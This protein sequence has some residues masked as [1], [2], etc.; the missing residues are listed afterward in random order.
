VASGQGQRIHQHRGEAAAL[1]FSGDGRL[2]ASGSADHTLWMYELS[3]GQS[4]K[5]DMSGLGILL[6]SFSPDSQEVLTINSGD[7]AIMRT[8]AWPLKD[9]RHTGLLTPSAEADGVLHL[10]FSPDGQRTVSGYFD[11]TARIWDSRSGESRTLAGHQGP[12]VWVAFSP[13]GQHVL[14]ASQD[15][16]VRLWP[17]DLP[18]DPRELRAWIAGQARR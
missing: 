11:G 1:A 9:M 7:P 17:D 12:V 18:R 15:G 2:L 16:T 6:A 3:S 8:R 5:L 4:H 13:D 14:T 10:A